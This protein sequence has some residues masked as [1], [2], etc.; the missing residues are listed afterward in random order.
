VLEYL[1]STSCHPTAD[2]VL[3]EIQKKFPALA[4]AT[5]YNTLEA[6][7]R[8]GIILRITVD[9]A[10]AR[11]DADTGPHAHF[12]CRLCNTVYDVVMEREFDLAPYVKGH[13]IETVRTYAYGICDK[14]LKKK[15]SQRSSRSI[16]I[17]PTEDISEKAAKKTSPSN[18]PAKEGGELPRA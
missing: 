11:Y 12:R 7:T 14:C 2:V 10:V 13:A 5:V 8:A 18:S 17:D 4:R 15:P 3:A 9:P 6:L 16:S 1:E